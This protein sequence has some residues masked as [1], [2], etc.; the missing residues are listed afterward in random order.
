MIRRLSHINIAPFI[1]ILALLLIIYAAA[2]QNKAKVYPVKTLQQKVQ[3]SPNDCLIVEMALDH[4]IT[5]NGSPRTPEN[6]E[7]ALTAILSRRSIRNIYVCSKGD[8]PYGDIFLLLDIAK[9]SGA[10]D[11]TLLEKKMPNGCTADLFPDFIFRE[12]GGGG[13]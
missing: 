7:Y 3:P 1:N 13:S 4:S 10:Q 8:L 5:L 12:G 6:L 2:F 9:R 11:I